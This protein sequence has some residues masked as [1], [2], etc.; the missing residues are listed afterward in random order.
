[1]EKYIL[2][3]KYEVKRLSKKPYLRV[4]VPG[5]KSM[6][7]RALLLS[8]LNEGEVLLKGIHLSGD[9]R[10]LI[11]VLTDLGFKVSVDEMAHEIRVLGTG[12]R[13]PKS[14]AT[15]D[16]KSA[17]TC[18][19]FVTAFLALSGG[20]Y[21][22]K[23]SDQMAERP[24][25]DLYMALESLGV[26]IERPEDKRLSF[27]IRVSMESDKASKKASK[28]D[29][30]KADNSYREIELNIDKSSQYLSA[31][32]MV[33]P[34]KY[35]KTL[36]KL[37]GTREARSYVDMTVKMM[38][39]FGYNGEVTENGNSY[40]VTKG[41]Y[42]V[43]EYTVEPDM[44]AACYFYALAS[45]TGGESTVAY[46]TKDTLQGDVK[47]LDVI[48]KMGAVISEN[49]DSEI[50]VKGPEDKVLKGVS[51]SMADFSDQALTVAAMAPFLKGETCI[52]GLSHIRG[53]E[54]DRLAVIKDVM[55]R[56]GVF[57]E[58]TEDSFVINPD[59]ALS[60]DSFVTLD[61][62]NDHRV[63]MSF[64]IMGLVRGGIIIDNPGCCEK[65]F[66]NY[67]DIIDGIVKQKEVKEDDYEFYFK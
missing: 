53:Q 25:E 30:I 56:I 57:C 54:S 3:D 61:T 44:S 21:N 58:I 34:L 26:R 6:T 37:T 5:S 14:N 13:V 2:K 62:Y 59:K 42:K 7:N 23:S 38:R 45:L 36:I 43:S 24:M 46:A 22:I 8:A 32:L 15:V 67:Y 20:S 64:T 50:I 16:V 33:L 28:E 12:G 19:R 27:P 9:S 49:N 65:T 41:E 31:L 39:Q 51:L 40:L 48:E 66:E 52:T 10:A 63:A 4:T 1:M 47:F 29:E 35:D 17:G 18:A 55:D 11:S 60:D